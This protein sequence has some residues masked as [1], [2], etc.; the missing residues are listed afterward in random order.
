MSVKSVS[1]NDPIYIKH[2]DN[3]IARKYHEYLTSKSD[4]ILDANNEFTKILNLVTISPTQVN[5]SVRVVKEI[6]LAKDSDIF[7]FTTRSPKY[8]IQ[9][10]R[11][12]NK[13]AQTMV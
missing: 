7:L 11:K 12:K 1:N 5:K 3:D 4:K 2:W 10:T 13:T 6:L 8:N 9:K